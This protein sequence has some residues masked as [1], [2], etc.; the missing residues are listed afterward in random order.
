M[1][2]DDISIFIKSHYNI[3]LQSDLHT[4]ICK[5]NKW[6]QDNLITL[7]QSKTY[8]MQFINKSIGNSDIQIT[9]DNKH[10]A[11]VKETKFLGLIIKNK[12]SWKGHID[13]IIPKPRSTCCIMRTVKPY[14]SQHTLKIIYFS[15][16]R[17]IKNYGLLSWGS[18]TESIK[19]FKLQKKMIRF[20]MAYKS[21]Q[22][23]RDIFVKLGILPLPC[24]YILSL[25]LFLNKNKSQF[26]VN[27]EIYHY[28]TRQQSNFHQPQANFT[29]YIKMEFVI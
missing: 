11:T 5:I 2:A 3:Q 18:S 28:V 12:L 9:T 4:V 16:F 6:F 21:N 19:I 26:T 17:S 1:F 8:F 22:S 20:M 29:K 14:V 27:S 15:Y 24:Q 23:C 7:N 10:I 25:L 13:Y